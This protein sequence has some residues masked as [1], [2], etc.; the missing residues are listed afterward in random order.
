[1][2]RF[3]LRRSQLLLD[4]LA[5]SHLRDFMDADFTHSRLFTQDF[6]LALLQR[7]DPPL[8]RKLCQIEMPPMFL[9]SWVLSWFSHD[10]NSF[11]SSA[12]VMDILVML[13]PAAVGYVAAALLRAARTE[14]LQSDAEYGSEAWGHLH[15][16]L[17]MLPQT[18]W[19]PLIFTQAI[20][21]MQR[22]PPC[23]IIREAVPELRG[24]SFDMDMAPS[25][26]VPT[27]LLAMIG[28][29]VLVAILA[30]VAGQVVSSVKE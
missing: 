25:A 29:P 6:M 1:M 7:V 4:R 28:V 27:A 26:R 15:Q 23:M 20:S 8:G 19:S 10:L 22:Y 9:L 11:E 13:P 18:C 2:L 3:G 30:F 5:R 24:S 17:K 16:R 21:M 14:I 12:R